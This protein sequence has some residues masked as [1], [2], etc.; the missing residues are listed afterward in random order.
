MNKDIRN[1]KL[2]EETE[3][4][5]IW[6]IKAEGY[7]EPSFEGAWK[8]RSKRSTKGMGYDI[9]SIEECKWILERFDVEYKLCKANERMDLKN[10]RKRC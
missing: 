8:V 10:A 1:R 3:E 6:E 5:T 4:Y 2:I 7:K 9:T